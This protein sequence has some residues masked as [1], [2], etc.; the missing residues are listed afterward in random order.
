[1]HVGEN[2]TEGGRTGELASKG[3]SDHLRKLGFTIGRLK[4]GTNPRVRK[5]SIDFSKTETQRGDE[6]PLPISHFT[7][8]FPLQPQVPCYITYTN[9]QTHQII[10]D[11]MS[12]SPLYSGIIKGIGPRYCP[13]IEDKVVKFPDKSRHQIFLE[14]EGLESGEYYLNGLSTSLPLDVQYAFL[15]TV[16]GLE[17]AEIVRPGYAVEYD[18]IPPTQI[19]STLETHRVKNLFLAGQINGTSGYEEAAAQGLWAGINAAMVIKG[20]PPFLL[21]RS[22]AYMGVLVD[23]LVTKGTDEPYR[24]FT[25][26]A[27]HRL[28]LRPDNADLRLMEK[29]FKL[30]LISSCARDAVIEKRLKIKKGLKAFQSQSLP[31]DSLPHEPLKLTKKDKTLSITEILRRPWVT[32]EGLKPL[33]PENLHWDP[34]VAFQVEVEIKYEGYLKKQYQEIQRQSRNENQP[35]PPDF[36]YL[37]IQGLSREAREKL[38]KLSPTT[39]GQASRIQGVTQADL[40]V[41]LLALSRFAKKRSLSNTP[42]A[43]EES[44]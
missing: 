21:S 23:D 26:K 3:L 13:S 43:F 28:L 33:L 36:S 44:L 35:I 37:E 4:T 20:L 16:P 31:A 32:Y 14:P 38:V 34:E 12:R 8:Q 42:L 2:K 11:N 15:N 9:S 22:E 1:M 41:L 6:N 39:F 5:D 17:R 19:S 27:E 10:L 25:S 24:L 40:A 7:T 30:G 18:F 29:G